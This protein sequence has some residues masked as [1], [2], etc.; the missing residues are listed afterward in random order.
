MKFPVKTNMTQ[1]D[2]VDV[3]A[4]LRQLADLVETRCPTEASVEASA[5]P[6]GGAIHFVFIGIR[7]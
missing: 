7:W 3:A 5:D 2:A 4:F 1:R 6:D